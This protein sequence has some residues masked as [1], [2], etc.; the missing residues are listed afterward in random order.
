LE[1]VLLH[2]LLA[3]LVL[4]DG[5]VASRRAAKDGG[6][7]TVKAVEAV[8]SSR[9]G[10]EEKVTVSLAAPIQP[11]ELGV[12]GDALHRHVAVMK[13]RRLDQIL[14]EIELGAWN[15]AKLTLDDGELTVLD[16]LGAVLRVG[17][18]KK[19]SKSRDARSASALRLATL[20][21]DT[22]HC[23]V[24]VPV[25]LLLEPRLDEVDKL[26]LGE[27]VLLSRY[28]GSPR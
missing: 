10:S 2:Q 24:V 7:A 26:L 9:D 28:R 8:L 23:S 17:K 6:S 1:A 20:E 3:K 22:H 14:D 19:G 25:A 18:R 12:V 21:I 5:V 4:L 15:L 13:E 11:L 27:V 16:L